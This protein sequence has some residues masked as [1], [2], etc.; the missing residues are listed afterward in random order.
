[1]T[2]VSVP[3]GQ[4]ACEGVCVRACAL[5]RTDVRMRT[6]FLGFEQRPH[7]DNVVHLHV[8]ERRRLGRGG[9]PGNAH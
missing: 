4:L 8:G 2:R 5:V 3:A 7:S 6:G 1:M 9:E